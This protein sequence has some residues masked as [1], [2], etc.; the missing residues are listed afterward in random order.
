MTMSAIKCDVQVKCTD[1]IVYSI[2]NNYMQMRTQWMCVEQVCN[3]I[4]HLKSRKMIVFNGL[5]FVN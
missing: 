3:A 1:D 4:N 5:S 2:L